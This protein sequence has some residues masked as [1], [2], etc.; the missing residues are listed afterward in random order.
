MDKDESYLHEFQATKAGRDDQNFL[1]RSSKVGVFAVEFEWDQIPHTYSTA[2]VFRDRIE[3][4]RD[5]ARWGFSYTPSPEW[6]FLA[7]YLYQER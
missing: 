1:L 3:S 4:E 6:D 5:T 7:D 2:S